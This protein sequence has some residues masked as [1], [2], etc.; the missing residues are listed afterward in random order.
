[1]L[2]YFPNNYIGQTFQSPTL[3]NFQAKHII[4]FLGFHIIKFLDNYI[5]EFLNQSFLRIIEPITLPIVSANHIT[6]FSW[7]N[8]KP[9]TLPNF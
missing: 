8:L 1:M 6:E 9:T 5:T 4:T 2:L 3:P 7:R